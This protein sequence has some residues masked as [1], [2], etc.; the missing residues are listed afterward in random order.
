[1][2]REQRR[3]HAVLEIAAVR[4]NALVSAGVD[5]RLFAGEDAVFGDHR[6]LELSV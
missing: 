1:V 6:V 2:V 5:P 4:I 3:S